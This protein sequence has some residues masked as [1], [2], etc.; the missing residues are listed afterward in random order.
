[1]KHSFFS[2]S[3]IKGSPF[4]RSLKSFQQSSDL[5]RAGGH[6]LPEW[7]LG[8][9][10]AGVPDFRILVI[11]VGSLGRKNLLLYLLPFPFSEEAL[12]SPPSPLC[13]SHAHPG[14]QLWNL[15]SCSP[16]GSSSSP[17]NSG[18][19]PQGVILLLRVLGNRAGIYPA[20]L[21]RKINKWI[22]PLIYLLALWVWRSYLISLII[23]FS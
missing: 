14:S 23:Q 21:S 1:M 13:W 20:L 18:S 10:I 16:W 12:G 4:L 15:G 6:V 8:K 9:G 11:E 2:C 5:R 22:N 19:L 7:S 17:W 3:G